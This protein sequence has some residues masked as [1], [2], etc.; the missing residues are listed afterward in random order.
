MT[1]QNTLTEQEVFTQVVTHLLTQGKPAFDSTGQCAYRGT[2]GSMC[3]VGCIITDEE[4]NPGMEGQN[5]YDLLGDGLFPERLRE[6][7]VLLGKLQN[8]HDNCGYYSWPRLLEQLANERR[9]DM[10][11]VEA[12]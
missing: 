2:E 9:L 6:H 11:E 12:A 3:A 5:V 1:N 8:I 10:P 4:Y 7:V